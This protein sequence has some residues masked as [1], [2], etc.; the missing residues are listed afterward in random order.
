MWRLRA[1]W[2]PL[3][4]RSG[5]LLRCTRALGARLVAWLVVGLH[6]LGGFALP[7]CQSVWCAPPLTYANAQRRLRQSP[8]RRVGLMGYNAKPANVELV[9]AA[10]KDGLRQQGWELAAN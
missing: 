2:A 7:A 5:A 1:A 3:P 10:F 6:L 4:A 9:L 8:C